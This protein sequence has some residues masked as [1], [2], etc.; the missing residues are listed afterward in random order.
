M[1]LAKGVAA[2]DPTGCPVGTGAFSGAA[3]TRK[4][5]L[6]ACWGGKRPRRWSPLHPQPWRLKYPLPAV[7]QEV[8]GVEE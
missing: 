3:K 5:P 7:V 6:P 2:W 1:G 4:G 8:G